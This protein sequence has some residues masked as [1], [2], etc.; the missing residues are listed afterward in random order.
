[1]KR[2]ILAISQ[3]ADMLK[4]APVAPPLDSPFSNDPQF[5]GFG[6]EITSIQLRP[7]MRDHSFGHFFLD[8]KATLV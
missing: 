2:H 5:Q 6:G 3:G 8:K 1:L 4:T 7:R